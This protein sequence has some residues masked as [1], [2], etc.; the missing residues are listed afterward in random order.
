MHWGGMPK[1]GAIPRLYVVHAEDE[2]EAIKKVIA[3]WDRWEAKD[4][5]KGF[6]E[7]TFDRNLLGKSQVDDVEYP[8]FGLI[9]READEEVNECYDRSYTG[10]DG[11]LVFSSFKGS[12]KTYSINR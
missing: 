9:I 4:F 7:V 5:E 8:E 3:K 12:F 6:H 10:G 11:G 2:E 1:Y